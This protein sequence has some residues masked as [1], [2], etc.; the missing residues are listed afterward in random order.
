MAQE[1]GKVKATKAAKP[2]TAAGSAQSSAKVKAKE[3]K[4]KAF[5]AGKTVTPVPVPATKA[6]AL[7]DPRSN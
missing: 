5:D 3:E 6:A 4:A 1:P 2:V 7:T